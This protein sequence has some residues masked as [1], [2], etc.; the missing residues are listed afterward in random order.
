IA[1]NLKGLVF[2]SIPVNLVKQGG[3]QLGEAYRAINPQGLVPV[4]LHGGHVLTQSMSICEYLDERFEH[5]PLLPVDPVGRAQVRSLAL[6]IAC[7]IHPLNN[8]RVQKYLKKQCGDG[9]D[10]V[11]WMSHWMRDGFAAI[12]RQLADQSDKRS[13][14]YADR[15]G[16]F[17]CFLV[18]QVYNA[19]RYGT[20][21][22]AFPMIG[23]IVRQCR[24]L[25]DFI[26][27]APEN[28]PDAVT[29]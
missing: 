2:E 15:P 27:A 1:L 16:L 21:M 20:D 24:K 10:A 28:Q 5:H 9:L 17:E 23:E 19:E 8:L 29:V 6:Q 22:S 3:E 26:N 14:Y 13:L 11:D 7:E 18:P 12:E 25:S 4:L